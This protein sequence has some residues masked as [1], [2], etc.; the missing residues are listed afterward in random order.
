[1][2]AL[3]LPKFY[4]GRNSGLFS[5]TDKSPGEVDIYQERSYKPS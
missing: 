4:I 2:Y 3:F 1:M 5:G